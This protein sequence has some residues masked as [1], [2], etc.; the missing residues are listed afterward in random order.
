MNIVIEQKNDNDNIKIQLKFWVWNMLNKNNDVNA[1]PLMIAMIRTQKLSI[2]N[3]GLINFMATIVVKLVIT[4]KVCTTRIN[5]K[6]SYC[7]TLENMGFHS[8]YLVLPCDTV[9]NANINE[10]AKSS[11]SIMQ[12]AMTPIW[13]SHK[14]Q[15]HLRFRN[16][17]SLCSSRFSVLLLSK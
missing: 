8:L 16:K 4:H 1:I 14:P 3:E 9:E 7:T 12:T 15:Q 5:I 6:H 13:I 2:I 11:T 17:L 10:W